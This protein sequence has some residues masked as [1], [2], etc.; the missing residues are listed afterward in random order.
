MGSFG[1]ESEYGSIKKLSPKSLFRCYEI[2]IRS[3]GAPV[4]ANQVHLNESHPIGSELERRVE[5]LPAVWKV[6]LVHC[7]HECVS[8]CFALQ[9]IHMLDNPLNTLVFGKQFCSSLGSNAGNPG[10]IVSCVPAEAQHVDDLINTINRP[11]SLFP[12]CPKLQ[13]RYPDDWADTF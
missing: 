10:D 3:A 2:Q 5:S 9:R 13:H 11:F 1:S 6:R 4:A 12:E 7:A 8:R